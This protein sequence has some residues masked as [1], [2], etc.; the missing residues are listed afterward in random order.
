MFP[1]SFLTRETA[2]PILVEMSFDAMSALQICGRD[3]FSRLPVWPSD[4]IP[5]KAIHPK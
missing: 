4:S 5:P 1:A 2:L 3:G